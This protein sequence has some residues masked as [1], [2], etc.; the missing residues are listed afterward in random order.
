MKEEA[1][2]KTKNRV[3]GITTALLTALFFQLGNVG[4]RYT[5]L[6]NS[7]LHLALDA[8][9]IRGLVQTL[10]VSLHML[11]NCVRPL[12]KWRD[13]PNLLIAGFTKSGA[14]LTFKLAL[15]FV[16]LSTVSTIYALAPFTTM[17]L[18]FFFLKEKIKYFEAFFGVVCLAGIILVIHSSQPAENASR[19]SYIGGVLL[20]FLCVLLASLFSVWTRRNTSET[21]YRLSILYPSVTMIALYGIAAPIS[22]TPFHLVELDVKYILLMLFCGIS[23]YFAMLCEVLSLRY[24][25]AGLVTLLKNTEFAWAYLFDMTINHVI[26]TPLGIIG[27]VVVIIASLLIGLS[28]LYDFEQPITKCFWGKRLI[29]DESESGLLKDEYDSGSGSDD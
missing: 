4:L 10:I 6:H 15:M 27:M 14:D 29:V 24:E 1:K 17:C 20:I 3:I 16:P 21:D 23:Y 11:V 26:P 13:L 18:A 8:M 25:R 22:S 2:Q 19:S 7:K 9:L 5:Y 28:G 12:E